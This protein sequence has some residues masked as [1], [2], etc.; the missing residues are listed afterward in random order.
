MKLRNKTNP[1]NNKAFQV[2][3]NT[4]FLRQRQSRIQERLDRSWQPVRDRPVL[5]QGNI[6]YEI[7]GRC[8]AIGCGGL[9]L[10]QEVIDATGLRAAIDAKLRLLQRHQPYFESDHV[11]AMMLNLVVG[12]RCLDD[13]ERH[14]HNEAFLDAVGARRIPG[15][16]TAGDFLRRFDADSVEDLMDAMNRASANVWQGRPKSER[17][18][19][20]LDVDGTIVETTGECKEQMDISYNGRW[21]FGP[22]VVSLAETQE[23]LW[24]LNRPANRPSHDGAVPCLDRAIRWAK[25]QAGFSKVRLRGDTDFSL[26]A[27]FDRWTQEKVEFVFGIDAHPSFVRRAQAVAD[28]DWRP[29]KRRQR[30]PVRRRRPE[31]VKPQGRG[32]K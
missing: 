25:D 28:S 21:G 2:N 31:K 23:V 20:T 3:K 14:R 4:V 18:L 27:E 5:E 15:A 29:M 24:T 26:T 1:V 8:Q 30:P 19:A 10:I 17:R 9:G 6:H 11:L 12:G 16:S 22:L 32:K 7:S 13:L